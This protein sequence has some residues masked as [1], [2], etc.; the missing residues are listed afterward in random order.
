MDAISTVQSL[1][2]LAITII[3]WIDQIRD[4]KETLSQIS[5]SV[6]TIHSILASFQENS[7]KIKLEPS[8]FNALIGLGDVLSRTREHISVL[9]KNR[10]A[11]VDSILDFIIP[12][13]VSQ[14]LIRD[15]QQLSHQL[16]IILFSFSSSSFIRER[17]LLADKKTDPLSFRAIRNQD[18]FEFWR[19]YLGEKILYARGDRFMEALEFRFGN[20]LSDTARRRLFLCLDEFRIGGVAASTLERFVGDSSLEQALQKFRS[21]ASTPSIHTRNSD[22]RLPLLIWVDDQPDNNREEVRFAESR[23]VHVLQFISTALLKV[24]IEDNEDFLR[25]NDSADSIR[26]IS[27]TARFETGGQLATQN[28]SSYLNITAGEIIARYLRGH[29]YRAPLLIFCGAGIIHTQYVKAYEATGSTCHS[30]IVRAYI[31]ALSNRTDDDE[32]WQGFDV[33][34]REFIRR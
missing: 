20:R 25:E 2:S 32:D 17:F 28:N 23:G 21:F 1:C 12:A 19:D 14:Q 18:V 22:P 11:S 16:T 29:L 6:T 26:F 5:K 27:D 8:L 9:R 4:K 33:V 24:W 31:R 34:D 15:E 7:E 13:R 3:T 10:R 30:A